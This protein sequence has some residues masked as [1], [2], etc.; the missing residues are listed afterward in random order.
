MLRFQSFSAQT[1]AYPFRYHPI[2]PTLSDN[3]PIFPIFSFCSYITLSLHF[4]LDL[5][6]S[7]NLRYTR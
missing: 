2:S 3:H 4:I 6:A 1:S 5:S 7:D